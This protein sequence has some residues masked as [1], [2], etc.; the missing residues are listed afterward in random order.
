MGNFFLQWSRAV[1]MV[2]RGRGKLGYLND[3]FIEPA[4]TDPTYP[5]WDANNSI[6][7]SWLVN[8][9]TD[10]IQSNYLCYPTAKK[11]WDSLNLAYSDLENSAQVFELRNMARNLNQ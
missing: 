7:M 2:V 11:I 8:S 5:I 4:K 3:T 9:M 1:L 10:E 6:V